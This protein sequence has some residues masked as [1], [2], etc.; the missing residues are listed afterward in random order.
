MVEEAKHPWPKMALRNSPGVTHDFRERK[1][2]M[3]TAMPL[4]LP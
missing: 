4:I 3:K 1:H 2:M